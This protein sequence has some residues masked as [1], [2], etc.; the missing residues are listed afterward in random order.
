M[1]EI[2]S[3][4][5]DNAAL[6]RFELDAGGYTAFATYRRSP[7][8]ITFLHTE[9]P[10]QLRERGIGSRLVQ[11]ALE[12]ARAQ[13]LTVVPRCSFVSHFIETHPEFHDLLG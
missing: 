9:V 8:V 12:A 13:K 5:H 2:P 11:G 7:G 1:A 10:P 3:S 6:S 4:V